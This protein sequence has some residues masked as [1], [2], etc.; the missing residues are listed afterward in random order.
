MVLVA[1]LTLELIGRLSSQ[2]WKAIRGILA[3]SLT[4]ATA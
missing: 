1:K 2:N 4:P 3:G